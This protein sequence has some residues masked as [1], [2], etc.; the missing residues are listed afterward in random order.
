MIKRETFFDF[1][2]VSSIFLF[3]PRGTGKTSWLKAHFGDCLYFDL[4]HG[5][6]YGEFLANPSILESRIPSDY[7]GWIII[8]EIQKVPALLNEVHRLIEGRGCQFILT[9]SSSRSLRRSGVNLLAGRALIYHMHP[10]VISELG[11]EFSLE[12]ALT[13]GLL[14]KA[15]SLKTP[16]R[17]L[18]S[19]IQTYLKE[20]VQEEALVRNVPLFT[21]FLANA[22]FSQGEVLNYTAIGRDVG[23][24]RQTIMNFFDILDDLLISVRIP[25]FTKR[26]KREV[27]SAPKFYYF[28]TG[29]YRA[30]RPKGPLDTTEEIDGAALETL[31]LQH[32]RA[33]NDYLNWQYEIFYWRTRSN[34]E[35]DFVLYGERGLHAFE[36]KRKSSLSSKDFSGLTLFKKD[37]DIAKCYMVYGGTRAYYHNDIQVIPFESAL[38]Q[39]K[40]LLK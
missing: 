15:F 25:V 38:K 4:L 8:D 24:S 35:V 34:E 30:L 36:I 3:G 40:E 11:D 5:E 19:Y 13:Y 1:S 14:P 21:R 23:S 17:Y 28:D 18:N 29:V 32:I 12:G 39:L 7:D 6:V 22:S 9:G 16:A 2:Q 10:F 20:E 37:Y 26:A 33:Y 31:F 27:I